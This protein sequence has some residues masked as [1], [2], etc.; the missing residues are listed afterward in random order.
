T[1]VLPAF[2]V[3]LLAATLQRVR[4]GSPLGGEAR[5][6][7]AKRAQRHSGLRQQGVVEP[8]L[9]LD[10]L[11]AAPS[12]LLRRAGVRRLE[13]A[14]HPIRDLLRPFGIGGGEPNVDDVGVLARAYQQPP[15]ETTDC[16]LAADDVQ[17]PRL[18]A[19]RCGDGEPDA[20]QL[21]RGTVGDLSLLRVALHRN[22]L[23]PEAERQRIPLHC[24]G[25][26]YVLE[27]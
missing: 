20:V 27:P 10:E 15:R 24:G 17:C 1:R 2:D 13:H 7:S 6:L 12:L 26:A 18:V 9:R 19:R 5:S 21:D 14:G 16:T 25:E 3:E 22:R 23:A 11:A 4:A 8:E